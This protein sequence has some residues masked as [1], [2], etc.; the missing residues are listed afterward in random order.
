[1]FLL[2]YLNTLIVVFEYTTPVPISVNQSKQS[3][4]LV[5]NILKSTL[6]QA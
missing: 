6:S 1:V 2:L 3:P 4:S 5:V